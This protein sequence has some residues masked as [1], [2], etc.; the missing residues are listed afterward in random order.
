A[1]ANV[2]L[3]TLNRPEKLNALSDDLLE[4]VAAA[5][6]DLAVDNSIFAV[7]LTG[8]DDVFAAGADVSR[9]RQFDAETIRTDTRP[10]I[11]HRIA[12]FPKPLIAAVEGWCLGAGTELALHCDIVIAS[13]TAVFGLPEVSLG[14][15]PGAGGTQ[16]TARALSKSDAMLLV[17]SGDRFDA[18]TAHAMRLVSRLVPAGAAAA[19]SLDLAHRIACNS[20]TAVRLAKAAVLAAGETGLTEGLDAERTYFFEAFASPDREIGVEA[21]LEKRRPDYLASRGERAGSEPNV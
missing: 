15:I 8:A 9:F 13:T 18:E 12:T 14:I 3:L 7:V 19:Q 2:A 11:W 4:A 1:R 5:L 21:F 10:G 17:L 6:D 16:R 20:P